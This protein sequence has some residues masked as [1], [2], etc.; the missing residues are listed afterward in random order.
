MRRRAVLLISCCLLL[1]TTCLLFLD[2]CRKKETKA[3]AVRLINVL[4][5]PAE[6]RS[7]RPFIEAIGT[8]DAFQEVTVSAEVDGIIRDVKADEGSIVPKNGLLAL[9]D[10]TDLVLEQKRAQAAVKQSEAT[11]ANTQLEFNRKEALV[12]EELVPKQQFEDVSTRLALADAELDRARAALSLAVT[13]LAKTKT[14]APLACVVKEKKVSVGDYVKVGAPLFVVIQPHP[15]KLHFAV[16]ERDVGYLRANQDVTLRMDAFPGKE[17]KGTV[18]IIYPNLDEKTR[19]LKVEA[20]VPNAEGLLKPGL[21]AKV[22]LYTG[23]S[24]D[25]IVV[26]ITSL[27]YEADKVRVFVVNGAEAHEKP[28]KLGNKYGELAEVAEGLTEGEQVVVAGQQ[29]LADGAKVRIQAAGAPP[30]QPERKPSR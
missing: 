11:L 24:K 23:A 22:V 6:K 18:N 12:K 10:D 26:P 20:L 17:F 28:V 30:A 14:Y 21:F 13:K 29:N 9:I 4:V 8:L 16:P 19:T 27:L 1:A 7:L 25:T 5:Q 2:G 15:I 3:E